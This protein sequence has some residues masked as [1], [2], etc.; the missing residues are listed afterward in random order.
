VAD[1]KD[2][3]RPPFANYD[4]VVYFGAGLFSIPFANRYLLEPAGW[5]L[6]TFV[7]PV[8][9]DVSSQIIRFLA[10]AFTVYIV[11]HFLAFFSSHL[12]EKTIDRFLGKVSSSILISAEASSARR[13]EAIR[14]LIFH[15]IRK[16]R[17]DG[18]LLTSIV[19]AIFHLP[20]AVPYAVMFSLGIFGYY[21]TRIPLSLIERLKIKYR[22]KS[23]AEGTVSINTKWYKVVEY[24]VINR[25]PDATA[26]M[27]NYLVISGLFRS[28]SFIFLSCTWALVYFGIHYYVDG[29]WLLKYPFLGG[30][31]VNGFVEFTILS[32]LSVFCSVSYIKFQR[33]YAEEAILAFLFNRGAE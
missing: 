6:P 18:A 12:V 30:T 32:C 27:Y 1:L 8:D 20:L 17:A 28:L 13:N 29:D 14:A 15:R 9:G 24:Y 7:A 16:I 19:R 22:E 33:R 23:L 26:R 10:I 31:W 2:L 5:H 4:V 3:V 21:D 25:C 11:G